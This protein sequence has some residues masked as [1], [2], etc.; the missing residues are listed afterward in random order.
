MR[1]AKFFMFVEVR[2][3]LGCVSA[4]GRQTGGDV[5]RALDFL[6]VAFFEQAFVAALLADD[7]S[8]GLGGFPVLLLLKGPGRLWGGSAFRGDAGKIYCHS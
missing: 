1:L 6:R 5:F 2:T 7:V 4:F 3:G 8:A